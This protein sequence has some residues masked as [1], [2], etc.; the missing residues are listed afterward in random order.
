MPSLQVSRSF[1]FWQF[2]YIWTLTILFRKSYNSENGYN[3]HIQSKKH[4]ELEQK[5]E[6]EE[7]EENKDEP[8]NNDQDVMM[9]DESTASRQTKIVNPLTDC[10]FCNQSNKEI[11]VNL[12]HMSKAH[13]F[14]LPDIEY[15]KDREGLVKYLSHKIQNEK[16]C[17]YC[18][19]RGKEWHSSAAAR[20]HML[21]RGHCK[22][23]YDETE[24]P[25]QLLE[26]YDFDNEGA[27]PMDIDEDKGNQ[28]ELVLES[29]VKLGHRKFL[30]YY[31]RNQARKVIIRMNFI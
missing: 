9:A 29:G 5:A 30:K 11:D 6:E 21:D 17:L 14:F 8:R 31:K 16:L 10:L 19:G 26:F 20:A 4:L 7:G 3:N 18:N 13:G 22:M 2:C 28:D 15:L 27:E 25:E 1:S 24:D 12:E 23:A